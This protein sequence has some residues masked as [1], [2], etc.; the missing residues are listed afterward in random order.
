[1]NLK[2]IKGYKILKRKVK[3]V[4]LINLNFHYSFYIISLKLN[5]VSYSMYFINISVFISQFGFPRVKMGAILFKYRKL[6]LMFL[7]AR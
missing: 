2:K 7:G 4:K 6:A 3:T 1:M 5:I